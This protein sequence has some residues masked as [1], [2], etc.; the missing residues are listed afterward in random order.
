MSTPRASSADSGRARR[1]ID[2]LFS[3]PATMLVRDVA[4]VTP[5][6]RDVKTVV[7]DRVEVEALLVRDGHDELAASLRWR[8]TDTGADRAQ[9]RWH[10]EPLSVEHS[11]WARGALSLP[12][13]GRYEFEVRAWVDRVG[14]W[15]RDLRRRAEAGDDLEIEFE[16]GAQ[17]LERLL[18]SAPKAERAR[19]R[20]TVEQLR[21]SNCAERV[22]LTAAL[23]DATAATAALI[24]DPDDV[25]VSSRHPLRC[26]REL[27]VRGAWYE[28]FPRSEGGFVDG[29]ASWQRL[30]TVAA[31][32][33]DVLY[34]PPIHPVGRAH[35]KGRNNT[36]VAGPDDVG[37]PWAIGAAEGGHTEVNPELG[38]LAD[39]ERFISRAAE[40][41]VE[42]ALDYALQCSPDHPWVHEHPEWFSHRPDGSI[43]YAENPPKK[44]QDIYPIDFWPERDEDRR[45]LWAACRDVLEFWIARGVS[46]FRVDN[47]HTKPL[48]F[49]EWVI[50]DV[51]DQ[52]P[53]TVFLSEAFTDP[54]MMHSL[55]EVG[56]SQSYTYFTWR[57]DKWEL[58]SYGEE[59][60]HAPS[61]A[62]FRPNL[63]PNTPDIL[64]GALRDGSRRA[65]AARA[66]LAATMAPSWGVY[67]GFEL[68]ENDPYP[69]K[70]EYHFSEKYELKARDHDD[71]ESLW[72]LLVRL[73]EVRRAHPATWRMSSLHFHH[74]DNDDVIAYTH[75]TDR[76]GSIDTVLV[77]VNLAPDDVREATVHL[78]LGVIGLADRPSVEVHDELTG[79]SWVWGGHGNYVRFDPAE[80]VAHVFS[81][82][83]R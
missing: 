27:A 44:Y 60:A 81:V 80:R 37:S 14:T 25:T 21:D 57:D 33:F 42:V 1:R 46:V 20:D 82:T 53:D 70:E 71:P 79:E 31:A 29:A 61:A 75:H 26:D 66:V 45:A 51:Q 34:L 52:H 43:R 36:L 18:P 32:G 78:D 6:G 19:L 56:F 5:T 7:G 12:E 15:R 76:D 24:E 83:P 8:R 16:V 35:R 50:R 74:V 13:P 62:W 40:L 68:C 54:P 65:F 73:N 64:A 4:P 59:L 28:F 23:D 67:S 49:W 72:P 47:P 77:V 11:G 2:E 9:R 3:R 17:L 39:V 10:V 22:R 41:E 63:W 69:D 58:T 30:E 48:S 38:T 55:G